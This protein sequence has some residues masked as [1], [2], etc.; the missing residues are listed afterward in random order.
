MKNEKKIEE[1][2]KSK[3][4]LRLKACT[5]RNSYSYVI[6]ETK[7]NEIKNKQIL[8]KIFFIGLCHANF[9]LHDL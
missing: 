3:K 7:K 6:T 5:L 8:V 9:F 2:A 1:W 4:N